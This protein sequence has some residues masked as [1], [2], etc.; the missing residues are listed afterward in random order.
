L[1]ASAQQPEVQQA[2]AAVVQAFKP[3]GAVLAEAHHGSWFDGI[4]GM[5]IY[6]APPKLPVSSAYGKLALA[7]ATG[8]GEMLKAFKREVGAD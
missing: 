7:Q 2:A 8:W 6:M 5:S 4:G 1:A 3:G